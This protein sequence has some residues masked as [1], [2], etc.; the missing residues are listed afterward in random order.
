MKPWL[1]AI[2]AALMLSG[3]PQVGRGQAEEIGCGSLSPA[4]CR[5]AG[6]RAQFGLAAPQDL[7]RALLLFEEACGLGDGFA[8]TEA[9]VAHATGFGTRVNPDVARTF[10]ALGCT[11]DLHDRCRD[12]GMSYLDPKSPVQH[13]PKAV[14]ILSEA[15]WVGSAE[16][17]A[18]IA[19]I[20]ANGELGKDPLVGQIDSIRFFKQ[21]C[22]LGTTEACL[23]GSAMIAENPALSLFSQARDF[24]LDL[25]CREQGA[26]AACKLRS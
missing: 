13:F 20:Q 3:A 10:Y 7:V 24:M 1:F 14:S 17:C 6:L 2:F 5:V 15:C 4:E 8:C 18:T 19:R 26:Q 11:P 22:A 25:A 9:G 12:H 16:G 21:A 23:A